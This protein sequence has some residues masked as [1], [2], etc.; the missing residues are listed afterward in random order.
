MYRLAYFSQDIRTPVYLGIN[1]DKNALFDFLD[2]IKLTQNSLTALVNF[3]DNVYI[4]NS[5]LVTVIDLK[6]R[7]KD[8]IVALE[9][10]ENILVDIQGLGKSVLK[11]VRYNF[12]HY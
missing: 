9:N 1:F 12:I 11:Y 7:L 2:K 10:R 4:L 8:N 3:N 6:K 5:D